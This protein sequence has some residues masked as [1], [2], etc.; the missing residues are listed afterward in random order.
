MI[1]THFSE[2]DWDCRHVIPCTETKMIGIGDELDLI[3][4]RMLLGIMLR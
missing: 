1:G 3:L 4:F 2:V